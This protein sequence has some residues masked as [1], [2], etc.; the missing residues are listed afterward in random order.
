ME[1]PVEDLDVRVLAQKESMFFPD[2][3]D[4]VKLLTEWVSKQQGIIC[5]LDLTLYCYDERVCENVML[6]YGVCLT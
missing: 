2:D 1:K 4:C 6:E 3:L 5:D